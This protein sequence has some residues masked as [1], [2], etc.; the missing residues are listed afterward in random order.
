MSRNIVEAVENWVK[1][2]PKLNPGEQKKILDDAHLYQSG[3]DMQESD[4][5]RIARIIKEMQQ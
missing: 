5:E 2:N 4:E 3:N 1:R